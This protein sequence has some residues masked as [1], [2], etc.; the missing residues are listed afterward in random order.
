MR[1]CLKQRRERREDESLPF[2]LASSRQEFRSTSHQVQ[3]NFNRP[4]PSGRRGMVAPGASLHQKTYPS[5]MVMVHRVQMP[6]QELVLCRNQHVTGQA[7]CGFNPFEEMLLANPWNGTQRAFFLLSSIVS[8]P[9][10]PSRLSLGQV[11]R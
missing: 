11:T 2:N 1:I 8:V 10:L 5:I 3:P 6:L 7:V 4:H 9:V